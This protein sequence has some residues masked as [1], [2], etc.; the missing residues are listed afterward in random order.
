LYVPNRRHRLLAALLSLGAAPTFY[1]LDW[2]GLVGPAAIAGVIFSILSATAPIETTPRARL[3]P[4]IAGAI[5]WGIF[6][7]TMPIAEVLVAAFFVWIPVLAW[8]EWR[9]SKRYGFLPGAIVRAVTMMLIM[10]AAAYAPFK[11]EDQRVGPFAP[12]MT[13][14]GQLEAAHRYPLWIRVPP[15]HTND[16]VSLPTTPVRLRYLLSVMEKQTGLRAR[17]GYCGNGVSLLRGAH[18]IGA[19]S[20][21]AARPSEQ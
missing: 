10:V 1:W 20:F 8:C 5:G 21:E 19:I 9:R 14:L 18:P 11:W 3:L 6:L 16:A 7:S 13:T 12:E 2:A 15:G 4:Q 17:I